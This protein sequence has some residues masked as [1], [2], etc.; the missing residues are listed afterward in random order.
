M[1]RE[2]G[3]KDPAARSARPEQF[4]DMTL[5]KELDSSGFIDRL[6]KSTSV[7]KVS[8]RTESVS[9]PAPSKEKA[10]AAESKVKAVATADEKAK[11]TAKQVSSQRRSPQSP[12]SR[13]RSKRPAKSISSQG[14][15]L[16]KLADRFYNSMNKWEKSMRP[17]GKA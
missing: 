9:A 12:K 11:P 7:A 1:F 10:A 3:I 5:M 8:P 15:S 17:I 6:Y 4:V 13:A 16:S 2:M 14:D